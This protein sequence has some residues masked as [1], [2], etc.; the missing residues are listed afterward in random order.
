MNSPNISLFFSFF[1][2]FFSESMSVHKA[3]K[4][5][6]ALQDIISAQANC[7]FVFFQAKNSAEHLL[8]LQANWEVIFHSA[9]PAGAADHC[10]VKACHMPKHSRNRILQKKKKTKK[11]LLYYSWRQSVIRQLHRSG[12]I[13]VPVRISTWS[14]FSLQMLAGG[15]LGGVIYL[16]FHKNNIC[17]VRLYPMSSCLCYLSLIHH[18]GESL[19]SQI[20]LKKPHS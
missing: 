10:A 11:R 19:L 16:F 17:Q 13:R 18:I 12:E 4:H 20:S 15:F 7:F 9:R 5:Y 2:F 8:L 3:M 6:T 1:F 14:M